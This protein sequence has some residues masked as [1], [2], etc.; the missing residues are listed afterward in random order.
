MQ[1]SI[2][3]SSICNTAFAL[4]N[5]V[6]AIYSRVFWLLQ[7]SLL[8]VK[9]I[10][11]LCNA[12]LA[13]CDGISESEKGII[14]YMAALPAFVC[15]DTLSKIKANAVFVDISFKAQQRCPDAINF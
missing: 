8:F 12:V 2:V 15:L 14:F 10:I 13:L 3:P 9:K 5:A 11:P 7:R 4:C 6:F 1:V